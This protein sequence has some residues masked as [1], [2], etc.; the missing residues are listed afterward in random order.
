MSSKQILGAV[1]SVISCLTL[2]I[3]TFDGVENDFPCWIL[4]AVIFFLSTDL[5]A[6]SKN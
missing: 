4:W 6:E 2:A 3:M 5:V 1:L